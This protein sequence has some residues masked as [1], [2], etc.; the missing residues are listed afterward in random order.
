MFSG[1]RLLSHLKF[2]PPPAKSLH[3]EYSGLECAM[4]LVDNVDDA[5][6]HIHK[7]GS[8][9]TDCIVTSDGNYNDLPGNENHTILMFYM[10]VISI[11]NIHYRCQL[12][13]LFTSGL[14][15]D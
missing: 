11:N 5:I 2:G 12:C 4:E 14:S 6:S 3:V 1:P 7:H 8:S 13:S 10:S 9:H 15:Q